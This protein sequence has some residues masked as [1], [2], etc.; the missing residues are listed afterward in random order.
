MLTLTHPLSLNLIIPCT[1]HISLRAMLLSSLLPIMNS[2]F[3]SIQSIQVIPAPREIDPSWLVWKGI[4]VFARLETAADF[5]VGRE[6]WDMVG[7]RALRE[8]TMF[9]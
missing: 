4:S 7:M 5:W 9:L 3:P 1:R 6:E 8:R 2:R